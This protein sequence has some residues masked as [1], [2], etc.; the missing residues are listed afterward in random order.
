LMQTATSMPPRDC[1]S[2]TAHVT[3]PKPWSSPCSRDEVGVRVR[4]GVRDKVGVRVS[5]AAHVLAQRVQ[6]S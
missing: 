4:V 3:P 2:T 6:S 5:A 1:V